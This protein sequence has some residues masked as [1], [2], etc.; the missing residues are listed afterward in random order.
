MTFPHPLCRAK[1]K[2]GP[3]LGLHG[4]DKEDLWKVPTLPESRCK[5]LCRYVFVCIYLCL[6]VC[7]HIYM[8]VC[9]CVC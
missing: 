3:F 6:Y 4:K 2:Q 1:G 9:M 5:Y 8:Y 7:M